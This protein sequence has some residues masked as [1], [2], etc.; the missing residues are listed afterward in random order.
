MCIRDTY[1]ENNFHILHVMYI[2]KHCS[3]VSC[4]FETKV[5]SDI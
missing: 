4:N 2:V 1:V 3:F 5:Y